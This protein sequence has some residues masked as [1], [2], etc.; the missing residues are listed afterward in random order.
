VQSR[1]PPVS[2][3]I[4]RGAVRGVPSGPPRRA[5]PRRFQPAVMGP[6]GVQVYVR[7]GRG[8]LHAAGPTVPPPR[9]WLYTLLTTDRVIRGS[10]ARRQARTGT[11]VVEVRAI[12]L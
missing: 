1:V 5:A 7:R 4:L 10:F 3:A 6:S 11:L 8:R 9:G 2:H 12:G